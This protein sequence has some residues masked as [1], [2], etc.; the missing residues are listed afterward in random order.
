MGK[1]LAKGLIL[2]ALFVGI[3]VGLSQ[4]NW[5]KVLRIE[6]VSHEVSQEL[7]NLYWRYFRGLDE[8]VQD[9]VVVHR[10]DS[11][12]ERCCTS[13]NINPETIKLHILSNGEINAFSLPDRHL[14]IYTGLLEN[15]L[16]D[17]QLCG[18]LCH[19]VAHM[20]KDHVMKK[21]IREIGVGSLVINASGGNSDF[22]IQSVRTLTS[23][24]YD[25]ELEREADELAVQYMV[26]A[27]INPNGLAQFLEQLD[28]LQNTGINI[29]SWI[30]THPDNLERIESIRTLSDKQD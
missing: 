28:K 9:S 17:E 15:T 3:W 1:T 30:S 21:L 26:T 2:V 13:N 4:I 22:I 11:L 16:T 5:V 19:E 7:G 12:L 23:T 27:G 20:E 18:V 10:L 25:R 8:E 6:R 14:V 29:P 24:A